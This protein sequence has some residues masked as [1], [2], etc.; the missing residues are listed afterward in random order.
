MNVAANEPT[1]EP[2]R[3]VYAHPADLRRASRTGDFAEQTA[4]QCPGALQANLVILPKDA[5]DEFLA[6]AVRNSKPCPLVGVTDPG[7]PHLPMLADDLD[8]RTDVPRYRVWRHGELDDEP[9]DIADLWQGDLVGFAIGC[10]FSFEDALIAEGLPVRHVEAGRNVP[11]YVT[12]RPTEPAGRFQ[13]PMVVSMR[14]MPPD[15]AIRAIVL[16]DRQPLAHGAPVHI[17]DPAA[18]GIADVMKP[19]FGDPPVIEAGDVLVWWACGVTPQRALQAAK[20]PFAITHAPGFMLVT[21]LLAEGLT[22]FP[23]RASRRVPRSTT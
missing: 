13:G 12:G 1:S 19:D 4:G 5:A 17:G 18:L 10:S 9:T 23:T 20:V 15:A 22:T 11:M 6:F 7:S 21:D 3:L 8:L 2:H 14:A 16:S